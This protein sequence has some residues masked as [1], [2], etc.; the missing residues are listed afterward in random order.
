[1]IKY[2]LRI[3]LDDLEEEI[4]ERDRLGGFDAN[5]GSIQLILHTLRHL[6]IHAIKTH[7]EKDQAKKTAKTLKRGRKKSAGKV[8]RRKD[9]PD[10]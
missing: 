2:E 10:M 9:Q 7:P 6:V 3:I 5:S 1:M 4:Q 8:L